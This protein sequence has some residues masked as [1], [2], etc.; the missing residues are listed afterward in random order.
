M[1]PDCKSNNWCKPIPPHP[2]SK[3]KD[4]WRSMNREMPSRE[5]QAVLDGFYHL[6]TARRLNGNLE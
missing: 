3:Y 2:W 4:C 6:G 1:L 5:L